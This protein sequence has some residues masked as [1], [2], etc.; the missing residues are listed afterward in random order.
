MKKIR[1]FYQLLA[2]IL[3]MSFG[4]G[5]AFG[6]ER[7]ATLSTEEIEL[8][9][10]KALV[11][12]NFDESFEDKR[13]VLPLYDI[14]DEVIAYYYQFKN[15]YL[16]ISASKEYSPVLLA[17][18]GEL[19]VTSLEN[20]DKLYYIGGLFAF[21]TNKSDEILSKMNKGKKD[22]EKYTKNQLKVNKNPGASKSWENYLDAS[23]SPE[24]LTEKI[25]SV[26]LFNQWSQDVASS[27]RS[28]ACGPTTISAITEYWRTSK[29]KSN[30]KGLN[31][32]PNKGAMINHMYYYQSL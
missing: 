21:R 31:V 8:V 6:S 5:A 10:K 29:G 25:L 7:V 30:L 12:F 18:K 2:L 11:K 26:P 19:R 20:S 22:S 1:Y 3:V 23:I 28:S 27:Y 16:V 14:N 15:H 17:G 13:S 32:Y 24:A 4:N 9:A